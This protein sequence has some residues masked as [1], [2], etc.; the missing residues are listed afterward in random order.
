M[1]INGGWPP[2]QGWQD[3]KDCKVYCYVNWCVKEVT[4]PNEW[5]DDWLIFI[6][7]NRPHLN[8]KMYFICWTLFG[9][10]A[11]NPFLQLSD[12]WGMRSRWSF[13]LW[14]LYFY[15][16]PC[17]DWIV[18]AQRSQSLILRFCWIPLAY[19]KIRFKIFFAFKDISASDRL[20]FVVYRVIQIL[21]I[22]DRRGRKSLKK[23]PE[24]I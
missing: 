15:H 14:I 20:H 4:F 13:T 3:V 18:S 1:N 10:F 7:A 6:E 16:N 19:P 23:W 5:I 22:M 17:R 11:R 12:L 21:W 9:S 24:F 8:L 2:F